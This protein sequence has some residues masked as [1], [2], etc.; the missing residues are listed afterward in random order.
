[1]REKDIVWIFVFITSMLI[2]IANPELL[3]GRSLIDLV[4]F[5][6]LMLFVFIMIQEF[7]GEKTW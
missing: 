3:E 5:G 1:M 7:I 4:G 6:L 2:F